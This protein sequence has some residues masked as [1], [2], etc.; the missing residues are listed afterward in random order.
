MI[1]RAGRPNREAPT[2]EWMNEPRRPRQLSLW[3]ARS[4]LAGSRAFQ[5]GRPDAPLAPG[6]AQSAAREPELNEPKI[7]MGKV[8]VFD[9]GF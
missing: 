3:L 7:G 6:Q 2:D 5:T 9:D 8:K 1:E 4:H